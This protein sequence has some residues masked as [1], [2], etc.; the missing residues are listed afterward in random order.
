MAEWKKLRKI[1]LDQG[2]TGDEIAAALEA[3][4]NRRPSTTVRAP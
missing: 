3:I 2:V 4:D 1:L